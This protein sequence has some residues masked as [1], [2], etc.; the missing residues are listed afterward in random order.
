MLKDLELMYDIAVLFEKKIIIW[1]GG[2][3]GSTLIKEMRKMGAGKL[4]IT[5]C[6]YDPDKWGEEIDGIEIVSPYTLEES[7]YCVGSKES[8]ICMMI[9]DLNAQDAALC[10]IRDMGLEGMDIYTSFGVWCG[11]H[12][13]LKSSYIDET[14]RQNKMTENAARIKQAKACIYRD[15]FNYLAF[16]PLYNDEIIMVYQP[17]RV[18]VYNIGTGIKQY[19]RNVA[20]LFPLKDVKYIDAAIQ[21][22]IDLKSGKIICLIKEPISAAISCMWDSMGGP[23]VCDDVLSM[24]DLEERYFGDVSRCFQEDWYENQMKALTG[25]NV[26]DYPF[27][28]EKGYQIIRSGNIEVLLL[29]MECM[30]QLTS[31]IGQFLGIQDFH[32]Y[33][34]DLLSK[35]PYRFAYE[36]YKNK[37]TMPKEKLDVVFKKSKFVR[38]FYT[39]QESENLMQQYMK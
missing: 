22:I 10:T 32:F 9:Q 12:Y 15:I 11:I 13:G 14:Y 20:D 5:I 19:G 2:Y 17:E 34:A 33:E 6:D 21:K 31:V 7:L 23:A 26:L 27:D 35:K 36:Q 37:F 3:D 38:H 29:K 30:H 39:E 4:G 8:I 18:G 1:G 24:T 25:L 28:K 16:I